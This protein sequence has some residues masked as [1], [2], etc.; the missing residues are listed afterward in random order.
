MAVPRCCWSVSGALASN[1][2]IDVT[3]MPSGSACA[4]DRAGAYWP[5]TNTSCGPPKSR[6]RKPSTAAA[7]A[8]T[9]ATG[10]AG[11]SV[12]PV[13][14]VKRHSSWRVVGRPSSRNVAAARARLVRNH[15]G[16]LPRAAVKSSNPVSRES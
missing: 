8:S 4:C 9:V 6:K 11:T 10:C 15:S 12:M 16:S 7:S 2:A 1:A 3:R 5:L 13:S 14:G